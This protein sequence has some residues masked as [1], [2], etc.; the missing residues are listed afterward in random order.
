MWDYEVFN[1]CEF[2]NG[3]LSIYPPSINVILNN[4]DISYFAG[5]IATECYIMDDDENV[6]HCIIDYSLNFEDEVYIFNLYDEGD[7]INELYNGSLGDGRSM[8]LIVPF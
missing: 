1:D 3:K 8:I 5:P 6:H 4:E 2:N 7:S